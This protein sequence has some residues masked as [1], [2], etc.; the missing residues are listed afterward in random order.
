M[1]V[2]TNDLKKTVTES[3]PF[4]AVAGAGDLA[5]EKLREAQNRLNA[6]KVEP[7]DVRGRLQSR[8]GGARE[9]VQDL[10]AQAQTLASTITARAAGAYEELT[11]KANLVYDDLAKRGRT[12]VRRI[13]RQKATQD[14]GSDARSTAT[15]VKATRTTAKKSAAS[16]K[17]SAKATTTSATRTAQSASKAVGDAAGKVG[18]PPPGTSSGSSSS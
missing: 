15:R 12:V 16:T 11:S 3:K 9:G 18:N 8:A 2:R 13:S 5:V 10:P 1:A 4:Y 7:A 14:L 6:L 17:Q